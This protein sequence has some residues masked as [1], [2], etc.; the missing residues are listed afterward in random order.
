[1]LAFIRR[2][3]FALAF[4]L[5]T[6]VPLIAQDIPLNVSPDSGKY[7]APSNA[8][9]QGALAVTSCG[10]NGQPQINYRPDVPMDTLVAAQIT[11]HEMVHVRQLTPDSTG[12]CEQKLLA[13]T[14]SVANLL[15]SEAEAYCA[16]MD[17][18][19]EQAGIMAD[20]FQWFQQVLQMLSRYFRGQVDPGDI[21]HALMSHCQPHSVTIHVA[22]N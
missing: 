8:L 10:S 19:R 6:V 7:V 9:N 3:V 4:L 16:Q 13:I 17:V 2:A 20:D 14:S 11:A 1:M 12:T 5:G 22:S 21:S 15:D 18:A